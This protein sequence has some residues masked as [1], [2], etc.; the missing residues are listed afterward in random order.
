MRLVERV[1]VKRCHI[2]QVTVR[3]VPDRMMDS[4]DVTQRRI[5]CPPSTQEHPAGLTLTP[6]SRDHFPDVIKAV[7]R[8]GP[9]FGVMMRK[10][11]RPPADPLGEGVYL[12]VQICRGD[13]F[14]AMLLAAEGTATRTEEELPEPDLGGGCLANPGATHHRP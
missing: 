13:H 7:I 6:V 1:F 8:E 11:Q 10:T 2:D 4:H 14:I 9:S 3:P 12:G 5:P